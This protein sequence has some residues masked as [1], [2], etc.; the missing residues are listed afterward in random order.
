MF[1]TCHPL[2]LHFTHHLSLYIEHVFF[3]KCKETF[4]PRCVHALVRHKLGCVCE[5]FPEASINIL[6]DF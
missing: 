2:F 6:N 1:S 4:L 5:V 3:F